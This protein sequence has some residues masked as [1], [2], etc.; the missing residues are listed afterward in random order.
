MLVDAKKA[1]KECTGEDQ[2][3]DSLFF[4]VIKEQFFDDSEVR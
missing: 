1:S 2:R 4:E 3:E